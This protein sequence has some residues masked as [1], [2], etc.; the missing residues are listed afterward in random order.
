MKVIIPNKTVSVVKNTIGSFSERYQDYKFGA[1]QWNALR[2]PQSDCGIVL[3]IVD[4]NFEP[5]KENAKSDVPHLYVDIQQSEGNVC[6]SYKL[7]WQKRKIIMMIGA[8]LLLILGMGVSL[9]R[10]DNTFIFLSIGMTILAGY[11]SMQ[12]M[13]HDK[14]ILALFSEWLQENFKNMKIEKS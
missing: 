7:K 6:V 14:K 3:Q 1:S 4:K 8:A 2:V 10:G 9:Y 5:N 13:I 11:R 12:N